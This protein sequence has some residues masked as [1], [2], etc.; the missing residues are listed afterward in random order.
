MLYDENLVDRLAADKDFQELTFFT[1]NLSNSL[2]DKNT[3]ALFRKYLK[4][5]LNS[6]EET[7]LLNAFGFSKSEELTSFLANYQGLLS[8]SQ[9]KFPEILN[10]QNKPDLGKA[11]L[12]VMADKKYFTVTLGDCWVI[13]L[14]NMSICAASYGGTSEYWICLDVALAIYGACWAIAEV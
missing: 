1:Y 9:I 12:K 4:S 6:T 5:N 7:K 10:A 3:V 14:A 8:K 2:G 11:A 13:L